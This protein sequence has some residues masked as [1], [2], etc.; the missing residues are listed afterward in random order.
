MVKPTKNA[1]RVSTRV[2]LGVEV[3]NLFENLIIILLFIIIV[4]KESSVVFIVR[5]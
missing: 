2:K 5:P 1:N 3:Q 4:K